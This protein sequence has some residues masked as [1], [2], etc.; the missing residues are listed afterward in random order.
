MRTLETVFPEKTIIP[1]KCRIHT[2]IC[3]IDIVIAAHH[4]GDVCLKY[5]KVSMAQLLMENIRTSMAL[6]KG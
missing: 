6:R 4:R 1:K 2:G 5:I 3:T